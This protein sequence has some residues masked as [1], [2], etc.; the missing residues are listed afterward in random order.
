MPRYKRLILLPSTLLYG[1]FATSK[2]IEP[3]EELVYLVCAMFAMAY[4]GL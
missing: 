2:T 4:S 3:L 1:S